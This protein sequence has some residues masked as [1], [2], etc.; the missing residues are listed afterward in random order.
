M[1]QKALQIKEEWGALWAI[2][3]KPYFHLLGKV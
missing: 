3:W 2:Y 1:T